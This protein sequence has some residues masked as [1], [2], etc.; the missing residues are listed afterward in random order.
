M[1]EDEEDEER[2][3][4]IAAYLTTVLSL[5]RSW[6]EVY[7]DAEQWRARNQHLAECLEQAMDSVS[8]EI[9]FADDGFHARQV[10]KDTLLPEEAAR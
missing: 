1:A 5:F 10:M 9:F 2:R 6:F 7:P 4:P 8:F 3:V